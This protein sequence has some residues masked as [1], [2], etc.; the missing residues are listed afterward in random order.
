MAEM[1]LSMRLG[2]LERRPMF[3]EVTLVLGSLEYSA[4]VVSG[5]PTDE[6]KEQEPFL[7]EFA[8]FVRGLPQ[9]KCRFAKNNEVSAPA[10]APKNPRS[11]EFSRL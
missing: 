3:M 9:E 4:C 7:R 8:V 11:A 2:V 1:S 10:P 6:L 5:K